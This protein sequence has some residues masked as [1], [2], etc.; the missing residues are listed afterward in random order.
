MFFFFIGG[1]QPRTVTLD[2]TDRLCPR[3]GRPA[4]HL[5]RTDQYLSL[6][7]IPVFPLKRGEPYLL[8]DNCG[9]SSAVPAESGPV[10]S[11]P[12]TCP[13]C[14]RRL[15]RDFRFCPNCGAPLPRSGP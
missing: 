8:C 2:S 13:H 11:F 14:G 4:L 6:F 12:T 9:Y 10:S 7:F 3:C 5:K 15:D 1:S